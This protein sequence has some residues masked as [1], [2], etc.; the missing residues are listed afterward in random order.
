M[1]EWIVL[2]WTVACPWVPSSF[3]GI[4]D[5]PDGNVQKFFISSATAQ[6]EQKWNSL[7]GKER[8][9]ARVFKGRERKIRTWFFECPEKDFD[10]KAVLDD[11]DNRTE[12]LVSSEHYPVYVYKVYWK[13][14]TISEYLNEI[15][16][17]QNLS[18]DYEIGQ[19]AR[20]RAN[21]LIRYL[22]QAI[23]A[24]GTK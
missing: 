6:F 9:T 11:A 17:L 4:Q 8:E 15:E 21:E 20:D 16:I 12:A 2:V 7:S 14:R 5:C 1:I 23:V 22:R 24:K 10:F 3:R 18:A 19:D 13:N